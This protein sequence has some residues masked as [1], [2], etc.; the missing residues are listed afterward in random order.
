[1]ADLHSPNTGLESK[2]APRLTLKDALAEVLEPRGKTIID[3]GC[4]D[5][6]I[7]RHLARQG[8]NAIGIEVSDAQLARARAKADGQASYSVGSGENLPFADA[9][10]D[11]ILY[12]NSFHHL[13]ANAM[14][15]ALQEAVRVLKAGGQLIVIEP[16]AAG[17]YF[18]AI[19]PLGDETEIR[20][21]AYAALL[22][23]P[24]G[25]LPEGELAY[26]SV[27]RLRDAGHF[28]ER[29]VAPEPARRARLPKVEA[30]L[31]RRFEALAQSDAE[32]Y[33][34]V[35]PMRRNLFRKTG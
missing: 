6:A 12:V 25:L 23:P 3:V 16:I 34:F 4:G 20:A 8:A 11:A 21:A 33:F 28:I 24:P 7:V 30:E 35:T 5:G 27:V 19:S 26:E 13:P 14:P 1:M 31:R 32:G 29:I 9:S 2:P 17:A 18:E 22:D 10:V 15:S